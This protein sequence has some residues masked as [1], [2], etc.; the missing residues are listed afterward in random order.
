[1]SNGI[2]N[3]E[4][5]E[6]FRQLLDGEMADTDFE[7]LQQRLKDDSDIRAQYVRFVD[8]EACLHDEL[9]DRPVSPQLMA[10]PK[11]TWPWL[12]AAI[13]G[14]AASLFVVANLVH[15]P[16]EIA[17]APE[18][19][20]P[21]QQAPAYYVAAPLQGL[22]IVAVV[23]ALDGVR[24][25]G[26]RERLEVGTRLKSG[27]VK[28]TDGELQ[29]DFLGGARLLLQGPAELHMVS[30]SS[31]TLV[32]GSA[33][34][35]V[36]HARESFILNAPDVAVGDLGTEY[37][38]RVSADRQTEVHVYAG[39]VEIS[40]L[41]DDGSTLISQRLSERGTMVVDPQSRTFTALATPTSPFPRVH[42]PDVADLVVTSDYVQQ[43]QRS[44][45]YLYWRFDGLEDGVVRDESGNNFDARVVA[46]AEDANAIRVKKGVVEFTSSPGPRSLMTVN[47]VPNFNSGDFSI[48]LWVMPAELSQAVVLGVLLPSD[49]P[50]PM[51]LNL[52]EL[53][54]NAALVH[55]P[56]VIRFLH[57]QPA[58]RLGGFNLLSQDICT[59]GTWTH[60][61]ATK[62]IDELK[63]YVNGQ[64]IRTVAGP[65]TGASDDLGY[66]IMLGQLGPATKERQFN[67]LIDEVAVYR[68]V[69]PAEEVSRHYWSIVP[70]TNS[71]AN[72]IRDRFDLIAER[73]TLMP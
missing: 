30:S 5:D 8:M 73:S 66:N 18:P 62:T 31:A 20:V 4:N 58:R 21:A 48:E 43:V 32:S 71:T 54:H 68:R 26:L 61:V 37:G 17:K 27:I 11:R 10:A 2:R 72:V 14:T 3:R 33:G 70:R 52:I 42:A 7:S 40:M 6:L 38:V 25:S 45:P 53:A 57:R 9:N 36:L 46:S 65:G 47:P 12:L 56:G 41:G 22:P 55:Q 60:V 35:R 69:M 1:M 19:V 13:V 59:P 64:L 39:E 67:G 15:R 49:H 50:I 16:D 44:K 28:L 29:L 34:V 23:T 24:E 51:H 63:L